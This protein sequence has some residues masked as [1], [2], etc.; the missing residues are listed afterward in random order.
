MY[1]DV[2]D[3]RTAGQQDSQTARQPEIA[4]HSQEK[5]SSGEQC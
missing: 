2:G 1:N 5:V 4:K 3:S